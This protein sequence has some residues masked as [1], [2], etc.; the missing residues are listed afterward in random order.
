MPVAGFGWQEPRRITNGFAIASLVLGVLWLGGLGAV[1][2]LGFGLVA[3]KQIKRSGG[4]QSGEGLALAGTILGGIGI[5]G[6]IAVWTILAT[7]GHTLLRRGET[8]IVKVDLR[9]AG[10]AEH[11]YQKSNGRYSDSIDD[12][13]NYGFVQNPFDSIEILSATDT[14]FCLSGVGGSTD[15]WYY[16]NVHGLS[17][18]P[19]S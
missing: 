9:E 16:D 10:T 2:A 12:L 18:T 6:A 11:K 19:C 3:L 13:A 14:S 1:F 5:L 17:Q 7:Q 4:A 15:Y 8:A